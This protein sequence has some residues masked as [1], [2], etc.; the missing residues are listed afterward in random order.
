MSPG[1]IATAVNVTTWP[2]VGAAGAQSNSTG[3]SLGAAELTPGAT[4]S[5]IATN[6]IAPAT[7]IRQI[8]ESAKLLSTEHCSRVLPDAARAARP[9]P[10]TTRIGGL[11]EGS[12][13]P[14]QL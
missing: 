13:R 3:K 6:A 4:A 5:A 2:G 14:C 10:S 8:D 1:G 12:A 9:M 11:G 7:E